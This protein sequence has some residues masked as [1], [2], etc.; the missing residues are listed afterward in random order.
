MKLDD[1]KSA[2]LPMAIRGTTQH[3]KNAGAF[4][5]G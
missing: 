4:E 1:A 3:R 2:Y 5:L